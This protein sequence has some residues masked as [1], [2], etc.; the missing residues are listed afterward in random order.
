[1]VGGSG[2]RAPR[3]GDA[4]DPW[5]VRGP[6]GRMARLLIA[7]ALAV[8][9][10]VAAAQTRNADQAL[11]QL[12]PD[13]A[14]ENPE[15]WALDT[16]AAREPAPPAET[17]DIDISAPLDEVPGMTLPWP[18]GTDLVDVQPLSPDPDIEAAQQQTAQAVDNLPGEG[19]EADAVRGAPFLADAQVEKVGDQVE[20]AF[21]AGEGFAKRA[22]V[23]ERFAGLSALRALDD[24]DDNLA[25]LTRRARSDRELILRI[26]RIYGYYDAE[27]YQ[28]LGGIERGGGQAAPA[29][30]AGQDA[31]GSAPASPEQAAEDRQRRRQVD[32][33]RV[34][35]RFDVIPGPLYSL[36]RIELGD[37]AAK[38][39]D[40]AP[41]REA[42]ALKPGDPVDTDRI[43]EETADLAAALGETG[44]AFSKIGDPELVIDHAPRTGDLSVPVAS[45]GKYRFGQVN[46]ALP[47]F[48]SSRHLERISRFDAGDTFK[49]SDV[50]DLRQAVLATG[51]VSSV[52]VTPR[53]VSAPT[54]GTPG[55]VDIDVALTEAPLRTIAG[56]V[57]FSSR[58]GFR[59][60]GSWEHRN[61]F[62]PEGMLRVRGVAGTQ[63][64]LAG[65]TYRR[66]NFLKRDQVLTADLYAQNLNR[67]AFDARTLSLT[68]SIERQTTLIFQKPW[69]YSAGF[70][71]L[72]TS[73]IDAAAARAGLPRDTY[74]IGAIPLRAGYDGSDDLLDPTRGFRVGLRLS[75][76]L[77]VQG[78]DR[79]TY[80]RAQFDASG[81]RQFGD[82]IIGAARV[83][84]G[85]IQGTEIT[86]IAPSRRFYAGG[87]GS[88]RGYG[89][90]Q[91]GPRDTVGD[92]SGGRSLTE[93]S[94]EARIRTG[95]MGGA[96]S[97]VPFVDA[98]AV[99]ETTTPSFDEIKVG[100]GIGI[101][102][103]TNFGP[104]R[105]DVGTPLNPSPG[106]SRIGVYVALGQ[107]F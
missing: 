2:L 69:V 74:F 58:E 46:S 85:T 102:Y 98:G 76:E 3:G 22:D 39:A 21:P 62:P 1:M 11:E 57:G 82:S 33:S 91:I 52:T 25:Q 17:L 50:D 16:D 89:F 84:L 107:A 26:L 86:S 51:L 40:A 78:G 41:L 103:Q 7:S 73:E 27:V 53:E 97:V 90:Q 32:L 42:F 65:V 104:I 29:G 45:G 70:E 101:R 12:I 49:K 47:R 4:G 15:S 77:S 6:H 99:D 44:Y 31:R 59:V 14:L 36:A 66:N 67:P 106:D 43:L 55:T 5:E 80:V 35:V 61:F 93:F 30:P 94:L 87:G 23:V 48:L 96:L 37:I 54:A 56:L 95:L 72:A 81:Y 92:P 24:D 13:Q 63:E 88:V 79:S 20:L 60:E 68:G 18:D 9:P 38:G 34:V 75:P 64:Q 19:D 71:I 28:T 105:I 83:R 8:F 10:A 100:V